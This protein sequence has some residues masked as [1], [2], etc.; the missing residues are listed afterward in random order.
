MEVDAL[1]AEPMRERIAISGPEVHLRTGIVQTLAL[2]LHELITNA[3]KYGGLASDHGRLRVSWTVDHDERGSRRLVLE[4]REEGPA[5]PPPAEGTGRR[6]Y[7]RE[8]IEVAL[9][10][11]LGAQTDYRLTREGVRCTLTLPLEIPADSTA[12]RR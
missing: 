6:G 2:A 10:F 8:L 7:G 3:R 5:V 9:P 12:E 1:G 4:W 11:A